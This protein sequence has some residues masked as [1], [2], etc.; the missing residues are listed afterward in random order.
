MSD[1]FMELILVFLLFL[2]MHRLLSSETNGDIGE[3][4]P[5]S[6]SIDISLYYEEQ[7]KNIRDENRQL[8]QRLEELR[9][10]KNL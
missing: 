6:D 10:N 8:V 3:F 9:A 2:M 1:S 5:I 7:L 4:A